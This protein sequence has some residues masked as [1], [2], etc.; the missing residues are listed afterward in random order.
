MDH[1]ER[2]PAESPP[3]DGPVWTIVLAAG[4]GRR[5]GARPKQYELLGG[6]RVVDRSLSVARA[7]ADHVVVVLAP[8]DEDVGAGMVSSG[9][10]DIAVTGGDQRADSVRAGLSVVDADAAVIVVHDA[11]RPLASAELH[12]AVVDA[13]RSG[14]DAVI[15]AVPVTDTI[16]RVHHDE[17]GRTVVD[18]PD[19]SSLVAVQT[20]QA[21]RAS[22]L[23]A[24][25]ASGADA[26][27]DAALVEAVGGTVVV[28]DGESTNIKITSPDDLAIAH[29]L[30]GGLG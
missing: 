30:L 8:G 6:E 12:R 29:V 10:A 18:T 15:P 20:P 4:S 5:Y 17:R 27:D 16:K 11:A 7:A 23:R 9:A 28:V 25:H 2:E 1:S 19:R 22:L 13:V 24:A 21:F 26:T 3:V 14:A